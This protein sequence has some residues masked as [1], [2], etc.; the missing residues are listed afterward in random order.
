ML[1]YDLVDGSRKAHTFRAGSSI[2]EPV[3][4]PR[5][6]DSREGEGF[7]VCTVYRADEDRSDVVVMDAENVEAEPLAVVHLPHRVPFGF[8]GNWR[9]AL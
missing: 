2:S 8:H 1:H 9:P 3:F 5:S 4:V 6:E 7:L